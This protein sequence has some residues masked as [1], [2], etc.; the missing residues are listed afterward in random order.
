MRHTLL[1]AWR[2]VTYY[3]GRSLIV[4]LAVGLIFVLPVAANLLVSKHSVALMAFD[5]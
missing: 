3:R 5:R 1:L 4:V 2:H